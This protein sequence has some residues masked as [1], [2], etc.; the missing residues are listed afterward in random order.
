MSIQLPVFQPRTDWRPPSL[1]ALP[2][3]KGARRVSIDIET[4]DPD[5]K[6]T[7]IGVRR[8]GRI[9]GVSFAVEWPDRPVTAA[10]GYYLPF[11][12]EGGDNLDREHVLAYLRDQAECF[13]G[14]IVGANLPYDVDYLLQ[15]GVEFRPRFFRDVQVAEPLLDELQMSYSLD[16]IARRRGMEGKDER[17]LELAAK[18]FGIDPKAD[19]WK[20][21]GRH[22]G[23]YAEVD[24][25]LPLQ[26]IQA[27]ERAL[28]AEDDDGR[29]WELY[30]LESRLLPVLIRMRRRGVRVDF[31]HLDVVESMALREEDKALKE[32]SRLSGVNV[33]LEDISRPTVIGRAIE[34]ATGAKLP[35]TPKSRQPSVK[36]AV[37]KPYEKEP[38]VAM[39]L[40]AKRFNK[41]RTTF[42]E[43]IRRHAVGD[44]IHCTF[45]QLRKDSDDGSGDSSGTI[46]GRLSSGN[47]NLQ[48]QPARDP[49]IGPLWRSIY[50]PDEGKQW[51]CLD[52]SQQEPRWVVHFAEIA[53]CRR[54]GEA[55]DRYRNDPSTDNHSMMTKIVHGDDYEQAW[56]DDGEHPRHKSAKKLRSECKTIYLGLLYGMGGAKL[57]RSLGY[58]TKWI[59]TRAGRLIEVAG[60]EGQ[61]VIDKFHAGVPFIAELVQRVESVARKRGYIRTVLGRR[62]HF[63]RNE[64]G[65]GYDWTY[66]ALNRLIQGSSA[67]Q[68]KKA[69][70]LAD[71]A[72]IEMQLQVHDEIDL[73]IDSL[74]QAQHLAEIMRHAVQCNVPAKVDIEVGDT[75]GSVGE[76]Q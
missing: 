43:S 30:D 15:A 25:T 3:W 51:A 67:D 59:E 54:A 46:S 62:C 20:L 16:N 19:M 72:G 14:D 11:G 60:D 37:L 5:L 38:A 49:E 55:A 28:R 39:Y 76:I 56:Y 13:R 18:R 64:R 36:A 2:S 31:E 69:M 58:E 73:S 74:E 33:G 9:V 26:L 68:T 10:K 35:V 66:K 63:P 75:W 12:H 6:K 65:P 24:A 21:P 53:G 29:L 44:R 4:H 17:H 1:G 22:V 71:D 57:C 8:K 23:P 27:Q 40:R 32:F 48:Q 41:L 34:S 52:Y 7:G 42:V 70:I 45:H 61:A 50:L 47:P